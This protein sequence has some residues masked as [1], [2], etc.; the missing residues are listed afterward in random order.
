MLRWL[1]Y[2]HESQAR[3]TFTSSITSSTLTDTTL[4]VTD[5]THLQLTPRLLLPALFFFFFIFSFLRGT[6]RTS[7]VC[8]TAGAQALS[9]SSLMTLAPFSPLCCFSPKAEG[10]DLS[11]F[12][13]LTVSDFDWSCCH[14]LLMSRIGL[15]F[16]PAP[17]RTQRLACAQGAYRVTES[18]RLH[19]T[20][21]LKPHGANS[22]LI[23]PSIQAM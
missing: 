10:T 8:L 20:A 3:H 12:F 16:L 13:Y 18:P 11:Y 4:A 22:K 14:V 1:R 9:M 15:S 23:Q 6:H 19:A 7:T 17:F 2:S 21:R 5:L